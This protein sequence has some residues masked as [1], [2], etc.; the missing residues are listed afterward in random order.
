M[1]GKAEEIIAQT[2]VGAGVRAVTYT[3][4]F[5]GNGIFAEICRI[6]NKALPDGTLE[7]ILGG[8]GRYVRRIEDPQ[9]DAEMESVLREA[10]TADE[11]RIVVADYRGMQ[12]P[13]N[14]AAK[15]DEG[16]PYDSGG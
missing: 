10:S 6:R 2:I 9:N 16:G 14:E 12:P 13:S 4:T 5:G 8:Y 11:L 1:S 3:P 7:G 15:K